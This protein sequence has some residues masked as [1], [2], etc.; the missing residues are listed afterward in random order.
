MEISVYFSIRN[1]LEGK[2]YDVSSGE[3]L[4]LANEIDTFPGSDIN[5]A[6]STLAIALSILIKEGFARETK[7]SEYSK[8]IFQA[9]LKSVIDCGIH[10]ISGDG[11]I[12]TQLDHIFFPNI[13]GYM[14]E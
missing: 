6:A 13:P 2:G 9:E 8:I 7:Q 14:K 12:P 10:E 3:W 1:I 11:K 4:K 5:I